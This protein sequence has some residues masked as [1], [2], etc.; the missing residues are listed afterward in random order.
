V[1][2]FCIV[3]LALPGA[4]L[5]Q[6]RRGA[7]E[8]PP[9]EGRE[10]AQSICATAC[11]NATALVM[12]RDGEEGWRRNVERMVVQKGAQI[13]PADMET[14]IKYLSTAL[15]PS[16]G[17]MQPT[18]VLPPGSLAPGARTV[19]DVRLP[20]G[21]GKEL[22]EGRCASCHDLGRVVSIPRKRNE[23]ESLVRNMVMRGPQTSP[24]TPA[25]VQAMVNYLATNFLEK[26]N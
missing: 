18:G 23:W 19:T 20:A 24:A 10:I 2:A 3:T 17:R 9:G 22:V 15:G 4:A 25:Q 12:K 1:L 8:L 26:T 16:A 14:L 13:F 6:E 11:H 7:P 21:P 5:A